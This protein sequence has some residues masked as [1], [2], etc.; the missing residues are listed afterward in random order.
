MES[1]RSRGRLRC[2]RRLVDQGGRQVLHDRRVGRRSARPAAG[3]DQVCV[4]EDP[5]ARGPGEPAQQ[6]RSP[7]SRE[8]SRASTVG[9]AGRRGAG[10]RRRLQE[11]RGVQRRAVRPGLGGTGQAYVQSAGAA[12]PGAS[13][14]AVELVQGVCAEA[15]RRAQVDVHPGVPVDGLDPA[16][17]DGAVPVARVDEGLAAFDDPSRGDPAAAP[18]EAARFVVA[19]PDERL[20]GS[21]GVPAGAADEGGEHG[22]VVP[23]G[24]AHPDDVAA[25][26]EERAAPA[27]REQGVVPQGVRGGGGGVGCTQLPTSC[28]VLTG[29]TNCGRTCSR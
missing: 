17:K 24:G 7:S 2:G 22:V 15:G 28:G 1:P 14:V 11:H 19:A 6:T 18:D 21:D 8:W 27:V 10:S 16:Q 26:S 9:R 3:A 29:H 23:C 20:G 25:W 4:G 5:P 12:R 13:L